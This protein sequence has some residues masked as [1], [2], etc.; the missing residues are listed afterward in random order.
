MHFVWMILKIL[1]IAAAVLLGLVILVLLLVLLVP[2]RYRLNGYRHQAHENADAGGPADSDDK[3]Y[4]SSGEKADSRD[5]FIQASLSWLFPAVSARAG[6]DG[7]I[8]LRIRILGIPV[9]IN[10]GGR[11]SD[12]EEAYEEY[13]SQAESGPDERGTAS[14]TYSS[15]R[16]TDR[17]E[18][19]EHTGSTGF[20]ED[21]G[22]TDHVNRTSSDHT[23]DNVTAHRARHK[24][25]TE[26]KDN[27]ERSSFISGI[28]NATQKLKDLLSSLPDR[29]N[30]VRGK[31]ESLPEQADRVRSRL[32]RWERFFQLDDTREAIHL[33]LRQCKRL[34]IHISP[35][36]VKIHWRYGFD[37]P[38]TTGQVT[39]IISML[40]FSYMEN[41]DIKPDFTQT[42][43]DGEFDIQGRVRAGFILIL[44]T[45]IAA[46]SSCLKTFRRFMK[47]KG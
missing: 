43:M 7:D 32:R 16:D 33:V 5:F 10:L 17:G 2:V 15:S 30:S 22:Y 1:G 23:S 6:Y 31:L 36:K 38:S 13:D 11:N 34:L 24:K 12:Y 44:I 8:F 28:R 47:C 35:R 14:E 20:S 25:S 21:T 37:D 42:R 45:Q 26:C 39:G 27:S 4:E 41:I 9:K 46:N 29:L 18:H 19:T 40:P 3:Q